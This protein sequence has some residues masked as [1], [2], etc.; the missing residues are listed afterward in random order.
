MIAALHAE[1]EKKDIK[2][3]SMHEEMQKLIEKSKQD[4]LSIINES[5]KKIQGERDFFIL[6]IKFVLKEINVILKKK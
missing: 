2:I 5:D 4:Q 6:F 3:K 1:S